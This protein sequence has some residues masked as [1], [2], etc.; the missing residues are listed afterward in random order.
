[1]DQR[2]TTGALDRR[3]FGTGRDLGREAEALGVPVEDVVRYARV[4][5]IVLAAGRDEMTAGQL[6]AAGV[7][8][9]DLHAYLRVLMRA[10]QLRTRPTP[11]RT[12]RLALPAGTRPGAA[13]EADTP[14]GE[15]RPEHTPGPENEGRPQRQP[16]GAPGDG[17]RAQAPPPAESSADADA[18]HRDSAGDRRALYQGQWLGLSLDLAGAAGLRDALERLVRQPSSALPRERLTMRLPVG[19]PLGL[20]LRLDPAGPDDRDRI[21][22]RPA[23]DV[24]GDFVWAADA[25]RVIDLATAP[26]RTPDPAA[27]EVLDD[28]TARTHDLQTIGAALAGVAAKWDLAEHELD[29]LR[30]RAEQAA[31]ATRPDRL[32]AAHQRAAELAAQHQQA[33]QRRH[34]KA[35]AG[36]DGVEP[37]SRRP[38]G[39]AM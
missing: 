20:A 8:G 30:N 5:Q 29:E 19:R 17:V 35:A 23:V 3:L 24:A 28:D 14:A 36:R 16:S 15:A 38:A 32:E 37:G 7:S 12:R 33:A 6:R 10:H 26:L 13:A 4:R 34:A 31:A 39:M 27:D 25:N 22:D 1:M 2:W 21:D 11:Q 18:D 9:E